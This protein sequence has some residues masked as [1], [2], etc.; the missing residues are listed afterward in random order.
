MAALSRSE[1]IR[2]CAGHA[3]SGRHAPCRSVIVVSH[4][5]SMATR[6]A[7]GIAATRDPSPAPRPESDDVPVERMRLRRACRERPALLRVLES[8]TKAQRIVPDAVA[9]GGSATA[10]WASHRSPSI[11]ITSSLIGLRALTPSS[12][13]SRRPTDG[14][15]TA[16]PKERLCSDHSVGS[17]PEPARTFESVPSRSPTLSCLQAS[18]SECG[19]PTKCSK[20]DLIVR[21]NQARDVRI[22]E[23]AALRDELRSL[24]RRARRFDPHRCDPRLVGDTIDPGA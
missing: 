21:R 15:P 16:S 22:A 7:Q 14:S 9:V 2:R 11:T 23:L 20:A 19:A 1:A 10:R 5:I 8:A 13:R 24:D 6:R 4:D 17:R 3:A 18:E 12:R